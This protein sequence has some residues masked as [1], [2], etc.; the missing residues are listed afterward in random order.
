M[1]DLVF[2]EDGHVYELDGERIPSVSELCRFIRLE[3]YKDA[4]AWQMEAAA[5]RG[6]KVHAAAESLDR[7]GAAE[8]EDEYLPYLEAYAAF[9]REHDVKWELIEHP[10]Y[11]PMLLYA[12]T[13]DRYGL[14]DG[15]HT[16]VD[17]KTTYTVHKPLC[18]AQLNL[19]RLILENR[20]MRV[21]RMAILH[22]K[23]GRRYRMIEFEA[24]NDIPYALLILHRLTKK[25]ARKKRERRTEE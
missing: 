19:Y 23:K 3:V 13:V 25:K 24:D 14:V 18:A 17:V 5:E 22:L 11:H 16:L 12:G 1:D 20:G 8:I 21:D 15:A 10:D 6:T 9:L 4:P 7:T 2:L